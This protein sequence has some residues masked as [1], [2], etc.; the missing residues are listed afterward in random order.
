M[1]PFLR[2]QFIAIPVAVRRGETRVLP[3][4]RRHI[5]RQVV[6]R[7]LGDRIEL[8]VGLAPVSQILAAKRPVLHRERPASS[9]RSSADLSVLSHSPTVPPRVAHR[10][11]HQQSGKLGAARCVRQ[12][13]CTIGA[14]VSSH[15]AAGTHPPPSRIQDNTSHG[16]GGHGPGSLAVREPAE[17]NKFL[18]R[19]I[20]GHGGAHLA[21]QGRLVYAKPCVTRSCVAPTVGGWVA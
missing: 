2:L 11:H 15:V 3:D 20:T 21:R 9:P 8:G 12:A 14:F 5:D 18:G 19:F 4:L 13:G 1:E 10:D 7:A 16:F 17:P 6:F